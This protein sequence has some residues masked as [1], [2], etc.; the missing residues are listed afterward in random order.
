M[1]MIRKMIPFIFAASL[2]W[3]CGN[4]GKKDVV[5][6]TEALEEAIKVEFTSLAE[7]PDDF[8]GK[9]I[10]VEG[11]VVHVAKPGGKKI[12]ITGDDP[13]IRLTISASEE[14]PEFPIELL[15]SD[16]VVEGTITKADTTEMTGEKEI[17]AEGKDRADAEG[18]SCKTEKAIT[19]KSV[20]SD[21][22][23]VYNKHTLVK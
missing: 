23:M 8:V 10:S 6:L 14:I 16:I 12:Y 17:H 13:D 18:D 15:G 9:K 4:S 22:M 5:T 7:N 3:S 21:L 20:M 2:L 11:K 19:G 1:I